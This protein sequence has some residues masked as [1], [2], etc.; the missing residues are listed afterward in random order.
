MDSQRR[1]SISEIINSRRWHDALFTTFPLSL[2]YFESMLLGDLRRQDC[3]NIWIVTD[4]FGYKNALSERQSRHVGQDYRVVPVKLE[5]GVFHPKVIYLSSDEGDVLVVGSGNLTFGGHGRNLEC[6]EVFESNRDPEVFNDFNQ[7]IGALSAWQ[8]LKNP[9]AEWLSLFA[10]LSESA[11]LEAQSDVKKVDTYFPRLLFSINDP[12]ADQISEILGGIGDI[13]SIFSLSPFHDANGRALKRLAGS[14]NA[15]VLSVG[16]TER[17]SQFPFSKASGWVDLTVRCVEP[18]IRDSRPLHAKWFEFRSGNKLFTLTGSANATTQALYTSNNC[19]LCVWN[20]WPASTQFFDLVERSTIPEFVTPE[21]E[22]ESDQSGGL[23]YAKLDKS[24]KNLSGYVLDKYECGIWEGNVYSASGLSKGFQVEVTPEGDFNY[25]DE[26]FSD[27]VFEHGVQLRLWRGGSLDARGWVH[28]ES[29]LTLPRFQSLSGAAMARIL[30]GKE[31]QDDLTALLN[32]FSA[33]ISRHSDVF[34]APV[35]DTDKHGIVDGKR[36][37]DKSAINVDLDLLG[38]ISGEDSG[39]LSSNN[40]GEAKRSIAAIQALRRA[41]IGNRF[42]QVPGHE[43]HESDEI[44]N[45]GITPSLDEPVELGLREFEEQLVDLIKSPGSD[46]SRNGL[47]SVVYE[48]GLSI[49]LFRQKNLDAGRQFIYRWIWLVRCHGSIEDKLSAL[50]QHFVGAIA[51]A[52]V[53]DNG[54]D[55]AEVLS[56]AHDQLETFYKTENFSQRC[57]DACQNPSF[58]HFFHAALTGSA[59]FTATEVLTA[60]LKTP[61]VRQ[62]LIAACSAASSGMEV[63]GNAPVFNTEAGQRLL[64]AFRSKNWKRKIAIVK[65]DDGDPCCRKSYESFGLQEKNDFYAR[66]FAECINCRAFTL[67]LSL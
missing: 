41:L 27:F 55:S 36:E 30:G 1:S 65:K 17:Q 8:A 11:Y 50:E 48:T 56:K 20:Q 29:I 18:S 2:S 19:E 24:A 25:Q 49:R 67:N 15:S 54:I 28:I 4:Q 33:S 10:D 52:T 40:S 62:Q 60:V 42:R 59:S 34:N 6:F 63:D 57:F 7:F 47:L 61:T 53:I 58:E 23:L 64:S 39:F 66:R 13:Q 3:S 38:T 16:A 43:P 21:F 32:F 44:E 26:A 35:V 14:V 37:K 46:V 31:N 9:D 51:I 5:N 12:I 45:G 22:G